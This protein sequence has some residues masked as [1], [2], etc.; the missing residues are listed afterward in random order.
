MKVMTGDAYKLNGASQYGI[1]RDGK[2]IMIE[3][4]ETVIK[5]K[6]N[7]WDKVKLRNMWRIFGTFTEVDIDQSIID[8]YFVKEEKVRGREATKEERES[9]NKY[10]ESI[11]KP[12]GVNFYDNQCLFEKLKNILMDY[13]DINGDTYAYNLTRDK[14]AFSIGTMTFDDFEEFS[15]EIIDDIVKYIKE[16]I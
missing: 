9:V 12:T 16:N 1:T 4:Y 2:K 11:S 8:R 15:E 5:I 10:I 3:P 14:A 7:F 6:E 13:F